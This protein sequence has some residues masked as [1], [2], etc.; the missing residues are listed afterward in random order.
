MAAPPSPLVPQP[1]GDA[2]PGI[3]PSA[4]PPTIDAETPPPP[5]PV[6]PVAKP[7]AKPDAK[8]AAMQPQ[9]VPPTPAPPQPAPAVYAGPPAIAVGPE[10][11]APPDFQPFAVSTPDATYVP[12]APRAIPQPLQL[13][14]PSAP[15]TPGIM[16]GMPSAPT[17]SWPTQG[18]PSTTQYQP[19]PGDYVPFDP[20]SVHLEPVPVIP[21]S[22]RDP[23]SSAS[24]ARPGMR[25]YAS[26]P[27]GPSG[28]TWTGGLAFMLLAPLITAATLFVW[29]QV[30][31]VTSFSLQSMGWLPYALAAIALLGLA[32]AQIDRSALARRGY[33]DLAS[34]FWVLLI[35][36]FIYLIVRALRLRGQ[37]KG[38]GVAIGLWVLSSVVGTALLPVIAAAWL[39]APAPDRVGQLQTSIQHSMAAQ[40]VT[41]VTC[42]AVT[43]L[44]PGSSFACTATSPN[45]SQP[46]RVT[47]TN[48]NG[49]Y[50]LST[51]P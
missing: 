30:T 24:T 37:G 29:T 46:I 41:A 16:P 34:P 17:E 2:F 44:A 49:D 15:P 22:S 42:P 10:P 8:H 21:F 47:I 1:A 27:V 32:S 31:M 13:G 12:L 48:W 6:E 39:T 35:P 9:A 23:F 38:A 26:A 33:F 28:S 11:V 3:V 43:S 14:A 51:N 50:A 4:P 25:A 36:P 20:N 5:Q 7:A 40:G 19:N 18:A 45:S